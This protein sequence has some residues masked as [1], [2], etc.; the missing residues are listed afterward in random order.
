MT[1][2]VFPTQEKLSYI[3]PVINSFE[4]SKYLTIISCK[5]QNIDSVDMVLNPYNPSHKKNF[6]KYCKTSHFNVLVTPD[7]SCLPVKK[8][9]DQ[10]ISVYK[11]KENKIILN[12]FSDFVQDKLAKVK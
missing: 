8:L 12:I 3:S 11:T 5:G 4:E 1:K 6:I 10:H 7:G 2:I 9:E